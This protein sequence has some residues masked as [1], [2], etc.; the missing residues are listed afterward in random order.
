MPEHVQFLPQ[1][2]AWWTRLVEVGQRLGR[3][4]RWTAAE[5]GP[6]PSSMELQQHATDT[7]VVCLSGTARIEGARC[8]LDL[9]VGDA[10]VLRPGAWHHHANLRPGALMYQQG[11]FAGYSDF[12]FASPDMLMFAN[13][14]EQPSQRLLCA[15]GTAETES[16]R[17]RHLHTLIDH[18]RTESA[19]STSGIHPA[20]TAMEL[21]MWHNLHR[22]DCLARV[23]A[24]SRLGQAQ[25]YRLFRIRWKCGIASAI[26]Q[27]RLRLAHELLSNGMTVDDVANRIGIRDRSVFSRAFRKQWGGSPSQLLRKKT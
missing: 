5:H 12:L 1:T 8:R 9:S 25:A 7:L 17:R 2:I 4:H 22:P 15:I 19:S 13:W 14:P 24:A 23:L 6:S 16:D 10:L 21:A 18:L 27:S 11:I 20:T 3:V 26:R